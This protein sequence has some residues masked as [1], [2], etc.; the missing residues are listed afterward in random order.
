MT[1]NTSIEKNTDE[2]IQKPPFALSALEFV[3]MLVFVILFA[4]LI[5]NFAFRICNVNGSSMNTTL[6]N[7]QRIITTNLFYTPKQDDII[8]FH[9]TG[10]LNEPLVKRVIATEGQSVKID[11]SEKNK[12]T[13]WVDG[14]L[15]YDAYGYYDETRAPVFPQHNFDY[16]TQIF[17]ATV[18]EGHVFVLGDN[19]NNSKD[20][21]NNTVGFVDERRIIGKCI[22][23]ININID[24]KK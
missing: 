5:Y 21:R 9:Q 1:D 12:M 22:F 16:D 11:F 3:E 23:I 14:E 4:L 2:K 13:I 24:L 6:Y 10:D 7:N 20:S 15:Y 19:R 17:E 8:V 18:P